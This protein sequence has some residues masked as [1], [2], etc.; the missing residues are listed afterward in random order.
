MQLTYEQRVERGAARLDNHK[1]GWRDRIDVDQLEV[2]DPY[3]CPVGQAYGDFHAGLVM[4]GHDAIE[5]CINDGFY[6][7][8]GQTRD[9]PR[10][11]AAWKAYLTKDTDLAVAGD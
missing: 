5:N 1:P 7:A 4:L 10:L 3:K 2:N 9:Y 8:L 11:T 6:E